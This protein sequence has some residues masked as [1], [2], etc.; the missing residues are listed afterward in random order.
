MRINGSGGPN[1]TGNLINL[2]EKVASS[3]GCIMTILNSI[4][5]FVA[6]A[7][8]FHKILLGFVKL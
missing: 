3:G 7:W 2:A 1:F 5:I 8:V 6:C 4:G